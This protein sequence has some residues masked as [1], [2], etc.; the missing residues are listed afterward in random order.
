MRAESYHRSFPLANTHAASAE[1]RPVP[2]W[3]NWELCFPDTRRSQNRRSADHSS[4]ARV[5][6]PARRTGGREL[7]TELSPEGTRLRRTLEQLFASQPNDQ[8]LRD[9]LEGLQRDTAL[10]ELMP[11]WGPVLYQRNRALFRP[12]ILNHFTTWI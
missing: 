8:R 10:A 9:H 2:A 12:F 3:Q 7:M 6:D 11:F 4:D 5:D 1:Q